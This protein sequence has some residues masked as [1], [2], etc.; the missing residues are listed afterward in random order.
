MVMNANEILAGLGRGITPLIARL[1]TGMRARW[2]G[3]EPVDR[4]R[5][6][7]A[8]HASHG[9]FILIWS[10]LPESLRRNTRPVAGADYWDKAGL[11]KFVATRIFNALL[12]DRV[13][14]RSGAAPLE[15]MRQALANGDSLIIFPEGTRNTTNASLLEFKSGIYHLGRACPD[16]DFVPVWI[17]NINRVLPK[18]DILPVPLICS[19]T[20]GAPI[21]VGQDEAKAA[22]LL[23]AR[24]AL[25]ALSPDRKV[26]RT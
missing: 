25:L 15:Q 17:E 2:Q 13:P 14:G 19:V 4:Q 7:Y 6:Y 8:N 24:N 10:A 1:L 22:F 12:I 20:F 3:C 21:R 18:G 9:D 11:R 23:R 16:V 5:L 26:K